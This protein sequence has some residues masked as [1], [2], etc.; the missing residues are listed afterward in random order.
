MIKPHALQPGDTIAIVSP[1]AGIA[2]LV[3]RR[4]RRGLDYLEGMGYRVKVMPHALGRRG[5]RAATYE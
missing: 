5:H 3:P 2:S 4:F 1:S